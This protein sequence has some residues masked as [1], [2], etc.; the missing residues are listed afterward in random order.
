MCTYNV[1]VYFWWKLGGEADVVFCID[2]AKVKILS[3]G[4]SFLLPLFWPGYLMTSNLT[5]FVL[6]M[7]CSAMLEIR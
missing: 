1:L 4:C 7:H 3:D 6:R 5:Q 2:N